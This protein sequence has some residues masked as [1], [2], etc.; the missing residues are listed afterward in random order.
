[1]NP[2]SGGLFGNEKAAGDVAGKIDP[3]QT[4]TIEADLDK[5]TLR[6]WVAGRPH[7]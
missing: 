6:F 4:L 3:H 2:Y 7:A 1:M 5:G